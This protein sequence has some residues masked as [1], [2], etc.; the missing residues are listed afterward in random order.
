MFPHNSPSLR[1][2]GILVTSNEL[3]ALLLLIIKICATLRGED[4]RYFGREICITFNVASIIVVDITS[5]LEGTSVDGIVG[6]F[7]AYAD[8]VMAHQGWLDADH[9]HLISTD[10]GDEVKPQTPSPTKKETLKGGLWWEPP[11]WAARENRS[12][13]AMM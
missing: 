1:S 13:A 10:E 5:L 11:C 2:Q 7:P 12:P 4:A 8:M 9:R 6:T 3:Y